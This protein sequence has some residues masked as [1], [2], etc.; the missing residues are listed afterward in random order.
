M[1]VDPKWLKKWIAGSGP[2]LYHRSTDCFCVSSIL[3]EGLTPWNRLEAPKASGCWQPRP[4]HI[5]M[6]TKAALEAAGWRRGDEDE[7]V[8]IDLRHLDPE[9][10]NRSSVCM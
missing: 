5:Y 2:Y 7:I 10:L 9:N 8:R 6:G 3:G 4:D 1:A